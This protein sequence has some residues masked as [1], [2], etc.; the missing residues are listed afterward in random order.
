MKF[1]YFVSNFSDTVHIH[2]AESIRKLENSLLTSVPLLT[3]RVIQHSAK[4]LMEVGEPFVDFTL[5]IVSNGN[6]DFNSCGHC[7][8][9]VKLTNGMLTSTL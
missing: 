2:C 9:W 8:D 6:A 3:L 7:I 5:F 4:R 1:E